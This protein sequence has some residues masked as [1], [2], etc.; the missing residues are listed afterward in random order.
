MFE[1]FGQ[2]QPLNRQAVRNALGGVPIA[3]STMADAVGSVC[4]ALQPLLS[5]VEA[6]VMAAERREARETVTPTQ[7][8]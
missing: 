8:G 2:H 1:K 7:P 6:H 5:L 4:T 3:L